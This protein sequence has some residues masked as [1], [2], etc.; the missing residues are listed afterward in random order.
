MRGLI[1]LMSCFKSLSLKVFRSSARWKNPTSGRSL[2]LCYLHFSVNAN[3][4]IGPGVFGSGLKLEQ[5]TGRSTLGK[6]GRP[7]WRM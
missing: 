7:V 6:C 5:E 1:A 2:T 3:Y 4:R